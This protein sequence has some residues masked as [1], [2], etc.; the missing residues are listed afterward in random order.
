VTARLA[1]TVREQFVTRR[2]VAGAVIMSTAALVIVSGAWVL[3]RK[4]PEAAS[5]ESAAFA[6]RLVELQIGEGLGAG[7]RPVLIPPRH[8]IDTLTGIEIALIPSGYFDRLECFPDEEHGM[9][10]A[11]PQRVVISKAF[12][13]GIYEV[14]QEQ[15]FRVMGSNPSHHADIARGD[16]CARNPV[17]NIE[18]EDIDLFLERTGYRL[19]TEAEWEYACRGG[20]AAEQQESHIDRG[21]FTI[22]NSHGGTHHVGVLN[23]NG[24]G[25]YDMLGNVAELCSDRYYSG[26]RGH[27][28]AEI[29]DP[30]YSRSVFSLNTPVH[31]SRG[32]SFLHK[33]SECTCSGRT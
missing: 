1:L 6:S 33:A 4:S 2:R 9:A 23:P 30:A 3:T 11:H 14:T 5:R 12:Y 18:D 26:P 29:V 21:A 17:E 32:G 15:W 19:P 10:E 31:V 16:A 24:F 22:E 20:V 7:A 27:C 13:I 25:L 8:A 28:E